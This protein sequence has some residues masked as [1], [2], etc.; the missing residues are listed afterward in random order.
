MKVYFATD[1][2]GFELKNALLAYVRD[3]LGYEVE[4]CGAYEQNS[5]DDY[6][7]FV[8]VA[9]LHVSKDP[10][11]S[12]AIVL[13]GSGQGEAM[14]ANR[15]PHVRAGVYYGAGGTQTDV[16]GSKLDMVTSLRLH[17]D[18]NVLSLGARFLS[19]EEAKEVVRVWLTT[20]FVPEERHVRRISKLG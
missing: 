16:G 5:E 3:E 12:R 19:F 15:F 14:C 18:A 13:G 9:A 4:D 20:E 17:N 7:D 1:H 10:E 11:Q 2:A 6:T 8:S